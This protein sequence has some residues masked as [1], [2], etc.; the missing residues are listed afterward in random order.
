MAEETLGW[1]IVV[2]YISS[3]LRLS[4]QYTGRPPDSGA[5]DIGIAAK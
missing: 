3:G 1:T 4:L 2:T 5:S